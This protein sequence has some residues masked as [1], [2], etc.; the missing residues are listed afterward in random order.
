MKYSNVFY[1]HNINCI[2]GV[3]SFFYYL[4]K[5]YQD[6]DITV[7]YSNGDQEQIKKLKKYARV[8]RYKGEIIECKKVFFNYN[9]NIIDN[10]KADEYIQI[11]HADYKKQK[12][13]PKIHPKITRYLGV[14]KQV[15]QSF[16]EVTGIECELAYNPVDIDKP[17]KIL[18]LISATRLTSEKGKD[19][20]IKLGKLLNKVGIPYIWLVF[21]NDINAIDNPNIKYMKPNLDIT[22]YIQEA[23][24]LVQLSSSEAYCYS[25]VESLLLGKPVIVT[26][27][28]VYNEIGLNESNSIRLDL[29]FNEI[30]I[31][32]IMK[33]YKF[34]Y[35]APKDNWLNIIEKEKSKYKEEKNIR[36]KV[37]A[38]KE[39][40]EKK[41]SDSELG[42]IPKA[43]E[44]WLVNEDR[45][46]VLLGDNSY[47]TTFVRII[48]KINIMESKKTNKTT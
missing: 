25:V 36:Y 12:I 38:L 11:I 32:Q 22:A 3:E 33:E 1:F 31:Q 28:P 21:T 26:D 14:S 43:G 23:D 46:D 37:E 48:E 15:C 9:I 8:K 24:F 40:E 7:F 35:K 47:K 10:V 5:K 16:K 17:K 27:L 13:T 39:Y 44:Q 6:Y 18:K 41:I 19:R 29:N 34:E 30:P 2:G 45:L 42:R 4:S 20:M